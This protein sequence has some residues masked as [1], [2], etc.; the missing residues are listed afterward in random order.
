M[1]I[2]RS[3]KLSAILSAFLATAAHAGFGIGTTT[4]PVL[5]K[6]FK[7]TDNQADKFL[8]PG[9]IMLKRLNDKSPITSDG[10]MVGQEIVQNLNS[11]IGTDE[12][13]AGDP[14]VVHAAIY[15]GNN[16]TAEAHGSTPG[17][18]AGVSLRDLSHHDGY[19]F[20]VY[21]PA[22]AALGAEAAA[23][24]RTW[25]TG[26][27]G[28]L[29]PVAVEAH[30]SSFG[31]DARAEAFEYGSQW[32]VAGGPRGRSQMFCSQ[33]VLAAYQA[34]YVQRL[35]KANPKLTASGVTMYPGVDRQASY[36]SPLVMSGHLN[37]TRQGWTLIGFAAI[38]PPPPTANLFTPQLPAV[39]TS[40]MLKGPQGRCLVAVPQP[41]IGKVMKN[42]PVI[43][44]DC[45]GH[46]ETKW[47][48]KGG[49]LVN[50][51]SGLC[52][53]I[54]D[55]RLAK[56]EGLLVWD[57]HGGPDQAW[58]LKNEQIMLGTTGLC[59]NGGGFKGTRVLTG[60]CDKNAAT[61]WNIAN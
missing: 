54:N 49:N 16:K 50:D 32:N 13:R 10:I 53:S 11:I 31:P 51:A 35:M 23:I 52:L 44:A 8:K 28:Y 47:R 40:T 59:A 1:N 61:T 56:D 4:A 15:L 36:T 41:L 17:E 42:S 60:S 34:A 43:E 27:M 20:V 18:N 12:T 33:F 58:V 26:R 46:P 2:L 45:T 14:Q 55:G 39:I 25:A 30:S 37:I 38:Q 6:I 24:A 7:V 21:R 22:D 48:M 3:L 19:L 5:S 57:C 29:L 9:D